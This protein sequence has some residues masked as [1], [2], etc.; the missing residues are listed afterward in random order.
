MCLCIA[1]I[2]QDLLPDSKL[3]SLDKAT[4]RSFRHL[5]PLLPLPLL[6]DAPLLGL[7]MHVFFGASP[8]G[9]Y[10]HVFV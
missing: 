4:S 9:W 8:G 1:S 2:L 3:A 7:L 10:V 5:S 6:S